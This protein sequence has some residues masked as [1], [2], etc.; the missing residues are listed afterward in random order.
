MK[1]DGITITAVG[2][3]DATGLGVPFR[4]WTPKVRQMAIDEGMISYERYESYLNILET[5]EDDMV[6]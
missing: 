1:V 3:V 4:L 6:F 5:I 2:T